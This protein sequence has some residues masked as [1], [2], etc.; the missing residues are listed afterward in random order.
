MKQYRS[1]IDLRRAL[2]TRLKRESELSGGDLGRLRRRVVFDRLAV[3]LASD[4]DHCWIL[5]G[6]A[7][8]EF[9]LYPGHEPPRTSTSH[10]PQWI[11]TA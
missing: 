2:E 4:P 10:S 8:L 7:A 6:G 1:G 11:S 9:R 5:K 3:R